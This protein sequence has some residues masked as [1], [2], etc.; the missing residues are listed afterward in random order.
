MLATYAYHLKSDLKNLVC[1]LDDDERKEGL[2]YQNLPVRIAYSQAEM[3]S[4]EASFLITSLENVRPLLQKLIE[5][6]PRR[7][8]VPSII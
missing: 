1:I 5:K 2:G 3:I 6:K 7:I 4:D 8:F